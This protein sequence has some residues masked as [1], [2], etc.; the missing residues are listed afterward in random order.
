M[1]HRTESTVFLTDFADTELLRERTS[2]AE[3][4]TVANMDARKKKFLREPTTEHSQTKNL[5]HIK[6]LRPKKRTFED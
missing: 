4:E 2:Q 1:F 3:Q 5:T 6:T